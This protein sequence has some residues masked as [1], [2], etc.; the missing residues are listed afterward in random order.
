MKTLYESI[1]D[2]EGILIDKIKN[3]YD[4]T[5]SVVHSLLKNKE[6]DSC[7]KYLN[8]N[9]KLAKN[10]SWQKTSSL[11]KDSNEVIFQSKDARFSFIRVFTFYKTLYIS[12]PKPTNNIK[13][14]FI[15]DLRN[16][17]NISEN[18]YKKFK[19]HIIK[20]LDLVK[21]NTFAGDHWKSL[22]YNE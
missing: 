6:L 22:K 4:N 15:E 1:L 9:L 7:I 11:W 12:F 8:D 13:K 3:K 10:G 2:D 17:Y 20:E 16:N 14:K 21:D 18:D 19:M 5:W